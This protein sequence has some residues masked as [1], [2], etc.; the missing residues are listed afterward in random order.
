M[1]MQSF[2]YSR[3]K[4]N[5]IASTLSIFTHDDFATGT[6]SLLALSIV[7]WVHWLANWQNELLPVLL[8]VIASALT[9]TDDH[10]LA[11]MRYHLI[12]MCTFSFIALAVWLSLPWP[13][14][15]AL[16]I[17]CSAFILTMLGAIGE[18]YRAIAFGALVLLLYCAL[19]SHESS[20]LGLSSIPLIVCGAMWYGVC[21]IV[22]FAFLPQQP[23]QAR[24]SKLYALLG[25][26]L[27]LKA[28]LLEP[29]REI[30]QAERRMALVIQNGKVVK[31]L[32]STKESLLSRIRASNNPPWLKLAL[33]QYLVAQDIHERTSSSHEDY[34]V[35]ANTFFHS[36]VLYRCQRILI[37]F[38]KQALTYSSV[39]QSKT[40]PIHQGAT[41]RAIEDLNSAISNIEKNNTDNGALQAVYAVRNNLVAMAS[42]FASVFT[43]NEPTNNQSLHDREAAN[44]REAWVRIKNNLNLRSPLF[45]H[46]LRLSCSL[47]IGFAVM[48]VMHDPLGYWIL[49]TILFVSQQQYAATHSRLIQRTIGTAVGLALGW[50]L[51]QLF[52]AVLLQSA[53]IVI[54]GAVFFGTRHNRYTLATTAITALL[55]VIFHQIGLRQELFP[56]RLW[57]TLIGCAIAGIAAWLVLPNWQ[58]RLWPNLASTSLKANANYLRE[59]MNHYAMG[60]AENLAYRLARRDAHNADAALSNSFAA[61]KKEPKGVRINQLYKGNFLLSSHTLL[62]YLSALGAHRNM[63]SESQISQEILATANVVYSTLNAL[64]KTIDHKN[65]SQSILITDGALKEYKE[66]NQLAT[67]FQSSAQDRLIKHQLNLCIQIL[68]TLAEQIK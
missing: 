33:H 31:A 56:A 62:N 46:A 17:A 28:Q 13:S 54:L 12:A 4:R 2:I 55:V 37:L 24:L 16:V 61:M 53:G 10:W 19:S 3:E 59:I 36:D 15:L 23:V 39:I 58:W 45:R 5:W 34:A 21:S 22:W 48:R 30:D 66:I 63:R 65:D 29:I 6:R 57:D 8:G 26:Y 9:E 49:L 20:E 43:S 1:Y 68:P 51:T 47:T 52:S 38:G 32:N 44:F 60:E 25:E 67:N 41:K 18:R 11:R 40:L 27:R 35:L 50:A 7:F 64:A 14:V 42:T